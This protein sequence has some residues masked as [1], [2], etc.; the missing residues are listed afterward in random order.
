MANTK[1]VTV[2]FMNSSTPSLDD[3]VDVIGVALTF[4]GNADG[5]KGNIAF[6]FRQCAS[7]LSRGS[8]AALQ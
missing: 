4:G 2:D 1:A 8:G 6:G 5:E 3:D 7:V